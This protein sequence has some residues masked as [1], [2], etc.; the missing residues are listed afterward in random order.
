MG[1][2]RVEANTLNIGRENST[3]KVQVSVNML[4]RS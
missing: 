1:W 2:T 3:Y 4:L